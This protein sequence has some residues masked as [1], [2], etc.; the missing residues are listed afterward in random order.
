MTTLAFNFPRS[1]RIAALVALAGISVWAPAPGAAYADVPVQS[2]QEARQQYVVLQQYDLSCA[3]AALAT[4]LR[5]QHGEVLTE[6]DVAIGLISREEYLRS[7]DLVR[8]QQGFSLLDMTRFAERLG[9]APEGYGGLDFEDLLPLAPAIVP[10]RMK[11]YNHFVVFRGAMGN[12]VLLAD[13]A[14]GNRTMTRDRF[15]SVWMKYADVGQVAFVVR[16]RD[17]RLPANLLA[18][19]PGDFPMLQ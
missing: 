9:Y 13:P 10:I 7:P 8:L 12:T 2:M 15:S 18:P 6:R 4:V 16:R 3:A 11:G 5:Y 19:T 17:G 1:G 14:Y